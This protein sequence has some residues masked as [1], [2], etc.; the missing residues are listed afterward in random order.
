[1]YAYGLRSPS[2]GRINTSPLFVG[3][4]VVNVMNLP[5]RDQSVGITSP[6]SD[7]QRISAWPPNACRNRFSRGVWRFEE[8]ASAFPSGDHTGYRFAPTVVKR[9]SMP[10]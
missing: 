5:S 2:S 7:V 6:A 3:V 1:M 9:V 8:N 10:R 4:D